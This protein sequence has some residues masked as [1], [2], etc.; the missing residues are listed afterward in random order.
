M[1]AMIVEQIRDPR[2]FLA[3]AARA[4]AAGKPIVLLHP[5]RSAAARASAQTHTGAMTGDYA[6][7]RALVT[8][9]GVALVDT[10]EELLD[11]GELMIR[12]PALPRAGAAVISE[13]RRVQGDGARLLRDSTG[14]DLPAPSPR[15]GG[16]ARRAGA[17]PDR[18]RPTRST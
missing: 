15:R 2:R 8:H 1:I 7:M 9:A 14:L 18:C 16:R 5:G 12:W 13:L 17:W 3:L 10:L 6:V 11:L 4:R